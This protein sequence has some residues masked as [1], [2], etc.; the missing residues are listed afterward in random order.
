MYVHKKIQQV[1]TEGDRG[2]RN[3]EKNADTPNTYQRKMESTYHK[4]IVHI[5]V[6]N[7]SISA[8]ECSC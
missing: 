8:N 4:V 1:K 3:S 2:K 7:V 5:S 6:V